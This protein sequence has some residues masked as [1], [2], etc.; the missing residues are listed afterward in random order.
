MKLAWAEVYDAELRAVA[1]AL[2]SLPSKKW[3]QVVPR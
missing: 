2:Q 1:A 3:K